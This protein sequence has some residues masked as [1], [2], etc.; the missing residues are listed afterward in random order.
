MEALSRTL[1]HVEDLGII[2]GIKICGGA[3]SINHLFF[4]DDWMV[5]CKANKVESQNLMDILNIFGETSGHLIN[6]NKSG[7]FFSNNTDPNLI[8]II[9]N[10]MG[11]QVLQLDNKYVGSPLFTYRS[12]IK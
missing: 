12:K 6:F 5:F 7:V 1:I 4:V 11:V 9:S 2:T 3:P 8:P 10:I